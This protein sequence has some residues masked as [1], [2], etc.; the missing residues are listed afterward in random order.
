MK[1]GTPRNP[2]VSHLCNLLKVSVPTA[3]GYLELLWHFAAEFAP[4]G[5]VGK[6]DDRWIEAALYWTG[7]PGH[8]IHCLTVAG[9][10]DIRP[11]ASPTHSPASPTHSPASPTHSPASPT[12]SP[13]SPTHSPASPTHSE[14]MLLVHD[15]HDHCDDSV[16][17]KLQRS[18]LQFLT[19]RDKVTG[20]YADTDRKMSATLPDKNCLPMP[21]PC[22]ARALPE[23]DPMPEPVTHAPIAASLNGQVSQRFEE[24]Y[25]PYPLKADRDADCRM[26]VSRVTVSDEAAAFACRDRY[27]LS[28]RVADGFIMGAAKFIDQQARNHWN[29]EWPAPTIQKTKQQIESEAWSRA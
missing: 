4:Q 6:F 21:E 3:V 27:L 28:K 26:W 2:K 1:R 11:L 29:G 15:W 14:R 22:L 20:Q 23:P 10:L 17:K 9:W 18:H 16:R 13:A 24:W 25:E 5:D 8:L 12:H 7:R 19:V